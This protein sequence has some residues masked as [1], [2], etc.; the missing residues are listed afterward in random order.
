MFTHSNLLLIKVLGTKHICFV[1]LLKAFDTVWREALFYE[2]L[3]IGLHGKLYHILKAMYSEVT[4]SVNLQ[5]DL[6][7]NFLSNIGVKQGVYWVHYY[8]TFLLTTIVLKRK[9]VLLLLLVTCLLILLSMRV[10]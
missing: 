1:D 10:T 4:Y 3:Q 9:N 8:L 7:D 6:T 5:S 2:L